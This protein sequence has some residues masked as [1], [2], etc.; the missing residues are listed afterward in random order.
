VKLG[1][2]SVHVLMIFFISGAGPDLSGHGPRPEFPLPG[3]AAG[4]DVI[5]AG[6]FARLS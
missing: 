6:G 5:L 2:A 3:V 4:I 1:I